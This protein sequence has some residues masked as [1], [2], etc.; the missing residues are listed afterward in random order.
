MRRRSRKRS[1]CDSGS[2]NVPS[3]SRGFWVASTMNGRGS[4]YVEWSSETCASF[5][6]SSRR[7][8]GLGRGAV[9]LVGEHDVGEERAR[10]EDEVAAVLGSHTETP[11]TSDGSMSE[12]NWMRWNEAA[13]GAGQRGGQRGLAHAGHV[14]DQQVAAR[15]Q[16]DDR[17]PDHLGL[18]HQGAAD[19]VL[20][21]ADDLR[22][23]AHRI[24][25]YSTRIFRPPARA[26]SRRARSATMRARCP[27]RS[28]PPRAG[29]VTRAPRA[30]SRSISTPRP[31]G[32]RAG[33]RAGHAL[34]GPLRP[35]GG[36]A[37][38]PRAAARQ[39]D[40]RVVLHPRVGGRAPPGRGARDRGW[41]PRDRLPRRRAREG[42]RPAGRAGGGDPGQEPGGADPPR[43]GSG[44]SAT[45]RPRGSSPPRRS[46][47]SAATASTTRRT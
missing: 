4:G 47:C 16:A 43:R 9:D 8:L 13:D 12:V 29:P 17:Q 34:A 26:G 46:A 32:W 38:H 19:A 21:T 6:A 44:R 45:G 18:A 36:A 37:P 15:D 3:Y 39:R 35:G 40:P 41:R 31:S 14:L 5:I 33:S 10:L 27:S 7:G 2:G 30:R 1:S 11:S 24:P 28:Q 22:R 25:L 20:E 23:A 42:Q